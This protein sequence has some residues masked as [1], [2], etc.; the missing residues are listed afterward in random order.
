MINQEIRDLFVAFRDRCI[1]THDCFYTYKAL[2]ESS[3]E[4]G[5]ALHAAASRFFHDLNSILIEYV[6]LQICKIT[7]P[8]VTSGHKN[9][10]FEHLNDELRLAELM[11]VEIE[12]HSNELRAYRELIVEARNRLISHNDRDT[13]LSE[14]TVSSHTK[15]SVEAFFEHLYAYTDA[16]GIASG[17][18][19]LDYRGGGSGDVFDLIKILLRAQ[20]LGS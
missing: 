20:E 4:V 7:D 6:I 1:W 8:A 16:V 11:T 10:T 17:E 19:P 12:S 9:L 13:I 14:L 3:P 15:Q 5:I 2:Y 18:G